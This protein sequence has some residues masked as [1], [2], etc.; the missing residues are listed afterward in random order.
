MS[1]QAPI[2]NYTTNRL[3]SATNPPSSSWPIVGG[4]IGGAA[5]LVIVVVIVVLCVVRR[6]RRRRAEQQQSGE[7]DSSG[8]FRNEPVSLGIGPLVAQS[9]SP[10]R[11]ASPPTSTRNQYGELVPKPYGTDY[12][13]GD[14][15]LQKSQNGSAGSKDSAGNKNYT[16]LPTPDAHYDQLRLSPP[17]SSAGSLSAQQQRNNNKEYDV[18][19]LSAHNSPESPARE[20]DVIAPLA[21]ASNTFSSSNGS[22][23]GADG[24]TVYSPITAQRQ[25]HSSFGSSRN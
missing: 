2:N 11:Q 5:L 7:Q 16:R 24:S 10:S 4:A 8:G 9:A 18:L 14:E 15:L 1:E 20:Y 25:S 12:V 23:G 3:Q 22:F 17:S 13:G 19:Q 6:Q 21:G